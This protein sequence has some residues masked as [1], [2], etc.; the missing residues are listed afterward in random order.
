M[1]WLR[2]WKPR[3]SSVNGS[4]LG[5]VNRGR[6][7]KTRLAKEKGEAPACFVFPFQ[8]TSPW[9]RQAVPVFFSRPLN[10]RVPPLNPISPFLQR[11]QL[12]WAPGPLPERSGSGLQGPPS[13][14][15]G[16]VPLFRD[17]NLM[18]RLQLLGSNNLNFF[19]FP[20]PRV[21]PGSYCYSLRGFNISLC[22]FSYLILVLPILY[23]LLSWFPFP[24]TDP[25]QPPKWQSFSQ[26][27]IPS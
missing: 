20:D 21:A 2:F 19:S 27:A 12:C 14:T 24:C 10:W 15:R 18:S 8:L 13:S 26:I 22:L 25:E 23:I 16:P 7:R 4:L 5:S 3:V 6:W 17:L 11:D 1:L 9:Q